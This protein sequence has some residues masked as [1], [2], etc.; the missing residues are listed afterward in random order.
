MKPEEVRKVV[1]EKFPEFAK[2]DDMLG[3]QTFHVLCMAYLE[4]RLD[5]ASEDMQNDLRR[6]Q[7]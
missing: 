4:G 6:L 3:R 5:Q 1:G 7:R 2:A